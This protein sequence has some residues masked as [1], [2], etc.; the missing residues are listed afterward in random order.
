VHCVHSAKASTTQHD[1]TDTPGRQSCARRGRAGGAAGSCARQG[2]GGR[3]RD[4]LVPSRNLS[5]MVA[6]GCR[7]RW[8]LARGAEGARGRREGR[9]R[10]ARRARGR[11]GVAAR[12]GAAGEGGGGVRCANGG[13][14]RTRGGRGVAGRAGKRRR[15]CAE[16][17]VQRA[18]PPELT[19]VLAR[20]G[21][22]LSPPT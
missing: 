12:V 8:A 5:P 16:R 6:R 7:C 3:W 9:A 22:Y 11:R 4:A 18:P 13:G 1:F 20:L 21:H 14:E 2:G 10:G 15:D 19:L 17:K